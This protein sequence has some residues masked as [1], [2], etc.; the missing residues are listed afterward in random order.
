MTP[1]IYGVISFATRQRSNEI[2]L[3]MAL[4]AGTR[5]IH[6]MIVGQGVLMAAVGIGLGLGAAFLLTRF[7]ASM[8]YSVTPTDPTTFACIAV[9]LLGVA[10]L[11]S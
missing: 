3:R 2:G 1:G 9:I 8:L 10:W 4:G 5:D 7:L 11:A 6:R